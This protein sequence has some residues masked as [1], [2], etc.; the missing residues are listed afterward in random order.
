MKKPL[1]KIEAVREN[2]I[3][4]VTKHKDGEDPVQK[5]FFIR[6]REPV[7]TAIKRAIKDVLA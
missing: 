5:T 6:R 4:V 2:G 1:I 3:V 7:K